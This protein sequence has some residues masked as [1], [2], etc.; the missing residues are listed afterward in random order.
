MVFITWKFTYAHIP[1]SFSRKFM[2][3]LLWKFLTLLERRYC[4]RLFLNRILQILVPSRRMI[5]TFWHML[6][7]HKVIVTH[8]NNRPQ[9]WDVRSCLRT[10]LGCYFNTSFLLD[11]GFRLQITLHTI[12]IMFSKWRCICLPNWIIWRQRSI[13]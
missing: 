3:L 5:T 8:F 9:S 4:W 10:L 13:V 6:T 2:R 11:N 1:N 12:Y 7:S